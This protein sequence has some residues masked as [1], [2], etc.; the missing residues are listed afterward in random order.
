MTSPF[1]PAYGWSGDD[2]RD[3]GATGEVLERV[4]TRREL[5]IAIRR[6]RDEQEQQARIEAMKRAQASEE[7]D[8]P[9]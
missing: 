4:E 8:V 9:L 6:Q 3:L 2:D 1:H 5:E 7:Q